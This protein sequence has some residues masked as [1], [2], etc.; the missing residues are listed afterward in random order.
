MPRERSDNRAPLGSP[1][2]PS[3]QVVWDSAGNRSRGKPGWA[4]QAVQG[5]VGMPHAASSLQPGS[6][7]DLPLQRS[8]G[9]GT[10]R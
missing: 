10:G 3:S 5:D 7:P 6:A 1:Q 8:G 4:D 9:D 2:N